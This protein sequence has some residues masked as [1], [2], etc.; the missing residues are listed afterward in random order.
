MCPIMWW[1]GERRCIMTTFVLVVTV[2]FSSEVRAQFTT[3]LTADEWAYVTAVGG[4]RD[5]VDTTTLGGLGS[6]TTKWWDFAYAANVGKVYSA[7]RNADAV[8][9]IDPLTNT[10]DITTLAGFGSGSSKWIGITYA[11]NVGKLYAAPSDSDSVLII[12]PL[13]NTTDITALAGLG[14]GGSKWIGITYAA[15]V[16]KMYAAPWNAVAVLIIDPLTNTT[17][18]TTLASLGLGNGKWGASRT[19]PT[20]ASCTRRPGAR[21]PC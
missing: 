17:D 6:S 12:D 1:Q 16:G 11:G 7:P 2:A 13:T 4:V 10:P 14:S 9:I 8:L 5:V 18:I 21:M 3:N 15:N 20:W 19:R